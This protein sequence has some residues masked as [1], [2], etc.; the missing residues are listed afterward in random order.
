MSQISVGF[1]AVELGRLDQGVEI[2]TRFGAV[3]G[4]R[5]HPV[6]APNNKRSDGVLDAVVVNL[7]P[8]VV[9]E[10]H[11]SAPMIVEI[12]QRFAERCL[13]CDLRLS[14]IEPVAKAL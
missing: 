6:F 11:E 4:V 12:A 2:G 7:E 3:D 13:R 5:E 9:D 14:C 10:A 8:S 1:E